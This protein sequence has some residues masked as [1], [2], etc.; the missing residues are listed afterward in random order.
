M[1]YLD[2]IGES[3]YEEFFVIGLWLAHLAEAEDGLLTDDDDPQ[4]NFGS[5]NKNGLFKY[6]KFE[7]KESYHIENIFILYHK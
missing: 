6:E 7:N 3:A 2:L 5:R 4:L 1:A